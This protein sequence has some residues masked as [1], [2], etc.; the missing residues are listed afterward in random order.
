MKPSKLS[1]FL[2]F[3][4]LLGVTA[5]VP[6]PVQSQEMLIP[7][8][9]SWRWRMGTN[10]VSNPN[11]LWRS[12]GFNDSGWSS[13]AAPFHYGSNGVGGDDGVTGGT[14]LSTMKGNYSCIF[15]RIPFVV[16]NVNAVSELRFLANYDDGFIGWINAVEVV[17][18]NVTVSEPTYTSEAA[19]A[20]EADPTRTVVGIPWPASYLVE[21]TNVLAVQAFNYRM[22]TSSD[23]RF[24]T[25]LEV[26]KVSLPVIADVVPARNSTLS[27]LPQITITFDRPVY[28]VDPADLL[29]GNQPAS[30]LS[31]APGTNRYTFAFAEP[32]PGLVGISWDQP[33]GIIDSEG[34]VFDAGS[35]GSRWNYTLVDTVAPAVTELT[36]VAGAFLG[37][38]TQTEVRFSEPVTKVDAADLLIEGVPATEVT[39]SDAGPYVFTF[40]QP[41][42]GSVDLAWASTHGIQDLASNAFGGGDWSVMLNPGLASGDLVIN[43]FAAGNISGLADEDGE[44]QDWIEILNRGTNA[45]NLLGWSLTDDPAAPGKWPFP[46]RMLNPGEF[47]VVFASGKDRRSPVGANKYHTNFKLNGFGEYLGLYNAEFPR[48]AAG[49]FTPEYP[50]QRND[51]SYGLDT[52]GAWHYFQSPTPGNPNGNSSIVGMLPPVHCSVRHGLFNAPFNVVLTVTNAGATIRYTTNGTEP[53]AVNGSTYSSPIAVSATTILRAAAFQANYLPST[54]V[55]RTYLFPDQVPLQSNTPP[56]FPA[57]WGLDTA[58]I[59]GFVPADYEMDPEIVASQEYAPLMQAALRALPVVSIAMSVDALFGP[60]NGIYSH[61]EPTPETRYLWE[62]PCSVEFIPTNGSS[63]FQINCGIRIQGNASR[64][65]KKTPKH[66]FRLFFKGDYG[67]GRLE[68]PVYPE[69][70]VTSFNTLVLRADF[71]NSWLHWD[72][73]QRTRGTRIRDGWVKESWRD[74]GWPG[75]HTRYVHLYLNGLYWGVYDFGERIDASFAANYYGGEPEEYDAITSRPTEAVDGDLVAY[76][77]MLAAVRDADLSVLANYN[78]VQ[79]HLDLPNFIDYM[80]LNFFGGNEDWGADANWN[81]VHHRGPDGLFRYFPWDCEQLLTTTGVNRVSSS[82]LPSGLHPNLANSPEYRLAFADRVHQHLFNNGALSANANIPRWQQLAARVD[83]AVIAESARWGDYRRDVHSYSSAPYEFYTRNAFWL[84]EINRIANEYFPQRGDIVLDQLRN[85]GLYPNIAAPAFSQHGGRVPAGFLLTMSAPAGTIYYTTNGADPRVYASGAVSLDALQYSGPVGLQCSL[86]VKARVRSGSTWSALNQAT[87][88]VGEL[89]VPLRITEIMYNP[90]GGDAFEFVEIQNVGAVPVNIGGFSFDGITCL[91]PDNTILQ[92]GAVWLLANSANPAAFATRYPSAVVS[93][94]F[95]GALSNGGERLA[96]LDR[97][98]NTVVS[99]HYDDEAGWPASADG[100]GYSLE[101]MAPYGD[102]SAAANWRAS[103]LVNGTPGLQ[104]VVPAPSEVVINEVAADNAGSVTNAATFPDWIELHNRS[105]ASVNVAGWSLTDDSNPRK[106][107][108]P[109]NTTLPGGGYLVVWC[110]SVTSAPGLHAGFALGRNGETISLFDAATNRLDALTYGLQMQDYTVG[111]VAGEWQL[112]APTPGATNVAVAVASPASLALNEWLANPL[113]G[114]QD[115]LELFNRSVSAPVALRGLYFTT[116]NAVFRY[117]ALSFVPPLGHIQLFAEESPGAD[118]VEFKLPA[119]GGTIALSDET[120]EELERITYGQQTSGVS[121]GRLPDGAA[122]LSTFNGSASP[123]ASNYLLAYTGPLLNEVLARNNRAVVSPWGSDA[124]FVELRNPTGSTVNLAGMALGDSDNFSKAW[125][126]PT[127]ASVPAGGYLVIWCDGSRAA[128]TAA[129]GPHNTG[130]S[131]SGASG[132]VCLFNALGQTVDVVSYGLQI[133]DLS[134][135]RV[136]DHWQLLGTVTPG[137]ANSAAAALGSVTSLRINEWM[138]APVAGDDWFELYNPDALPVDLSGVHVTDDPSIIGIEQSPIAPLSFI[139]GRDWVRLAADGHPGNGR[140]HTTFSLDRNGETLRLYDTDLVL[141]DAV[142]FGL[143]ADDASQGRLT[144]GAPAILSFPTTATPGAANYLPLDDVVIS[145]LLTHTDPPL[146]DAVELF[147]PTTNSVNLGGW[148]LSDSTSDFKRFRIPDGTSLSP[149]G[150]MVFYQDQFGP[151]DGETDLPPLFSF[152]SAHGDEAHL[153][154]ADGAGNL[155]GYRASISFDA[156]ANGVS[157]GRH[158]TGVGVDFVPMSQRTFGVDDPTSL[159]QFRTGTG[160]N[161]AYPLVGPVVINEIMYHPPDLGTNSADLEEFIELLNLSDTAVALFDTAHP[162][163]VWR[164]ANAV[165]FHFANNTILPAHG[166]LVVVPFDPVTNTTA[167]AAFQSRYGATGML[168]GPYA[169]KL[170][171]AGEALELW[172][173]DAPQAV[174]HPDAGFVPQL[175]VERVVYSD[176][177]Y[178]P[179]NADG[180]GHSLQR[181]VAANYGNDP[182]N[183]RAAVPTAG[184]ANPSASP[185]TIIAHPQNREVFIGENAS[186]SVIATGDA[187]LSYQWLSNNVPLVG[188]NAT[189]LVLTQVRAA[190]AGDYRVQIMNPVTSVL[191]DAATLAVVAPPTGNAGLINANTL[192][193]AFSVISGRTYQVEYKNHLTELNWLP[194]GAPVSANNDTLIV[195]EGIAGPSERF[196]RLVVLP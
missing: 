163:N 109:A 115:W 116:S 107:V 77:A 164:L 28:G 1:K 74:M 153:S 97:N 196:Y 57:G 42:P 85:A 186:F 35:P 29:I 146:E 18:A 168:V 192:R 56:G 30:T 184:G 169:G 65:P 44:A 144:D 20:H 124:D 71:N 137:Q 152:N 126:F 37:Q 157:F 194:L 68:Y 76:N 84:P 14:I 167:L 130:F 41:F 156:A 132:D 22:A 147:N 32:L 63:G 104:P 10:E 195:E 91:I 134:L 117:G 129:G 81:A 49:E 139:D 177:G 33:P 88:T 182:V 47:L 112:T 190:D 51:H 125:V 4:L 58:F 94:Y 80:L 118:Q 151:A 75:C 52:A 154:E 78:L 110:D 123:G 171:N 60:V 122:N 19:S 62:R 138:A 106:F 3:F 24:E 17:R 59:H 143:Q 120:G 172:R 15:L 45:V 176:A 162:T 26:T 93:G 98:G 5:A 183:W 189:N 121:E 39:G 9:A 72:P 23:F 12:A 2:R 40:E 54:P 34:N 73:D 149:G 69:S 108:F 111:R 191:S 155:T 50:E 16:T 6:P 179:T 165:S 53:T 135:G 46:S 142:D 82:D 21:G 55:T 193:L 8:G 25:R 173:P 187:P 114:E 161:N 86:T 89:G 38:L 105:G 113:A 36:P 43:E 136:G 133:Q 188:Q 13:G 148:Y 170:D 67:P 66:P 140:D 166:T 96:L 31:G 145:E 141:V 90:Q 101:L 87:F 159:A 175:L 180:L 70:S 127:G 95:G 64:T 178:W 27:A 100:G 185:P 128:S 92:P 174:P 131:L 181:L 99:V 7:N 61:P 83:S 160:T 158:Q 79:T 48:L 119:A 103:T 150:F 11:T 102:S